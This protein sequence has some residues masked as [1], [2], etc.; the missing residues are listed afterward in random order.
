MRTAA[1]C[2]TCA[3][4]INATCIIYDG[5]NLLNINTLTLDNLQ[6]ILGN[7]NTTVGGINT[8]ITGIN[9]S[10]T[11]INGSI[12]TLTAGLALK[13]NTANKSND[14]TLSANSSV[15]FPTQHAVKAYADALVVGLL[16]DRG[17]Y[18][19]SPTSPGAYPSTGGSG[20]GGAIMKGDIWFINGNGYLGTT[21]VVIGA[22][23]RALVNSPSSPAGWDILDANLGIVPE[24]VANKVTTQADITTYGSSTVKYPAV[25]AIK[26][27]VD[28]LVSTSVGAVDLNSVLTIG[29]TSLLDANIGILGLWDGPNSFYNYISS[30]DYGFDFKL[31]SGTNLVHMELGLLSFYNTL[32]NPATLDSS[33]LTSNRT[34]NL[35]DQSGTIPLS[36]NG[37]TADSTGNIVINNNISTLKISINS[38]ELLNLAVVPKLLLAGQGVG[39]V[40]RLMDASIAYNH[41]TTAY[42]P[43]QLRFTIGSVAIASN[44]ALSLNSTGIAFNDVP[45]VNLTSAQSNNQALYLTSISNPTGGNGTIDV[46]ITYQ[47]ITL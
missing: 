5:P 26:N 45:A 4:Y 17:N 6:V 29:D 2:P 41:N 3:T 15:L 24:N 22:S 9:T 42:S 23:V 40:I 28:N 37:Q 25:K 38:S 33:L 35:P 44:S 27:Y 43:T 14:I 10:I 7:I 46:F 1:I 36:V 47:V 12:S 18:T 11:T 39:T 31:N 13:E 8:S 30:S 20:T 34:Y 16:D 32:G 21:A 19:P